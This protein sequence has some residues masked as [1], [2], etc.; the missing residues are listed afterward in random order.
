[1]VISKRIKTI[2]RKLHIK[3]SY[4]AH[5]MGVSQQFY[6]SIESGEKVYSLATIS[7]IATIFEIDLL[8]ILTPEIPITDETITLFKK[9]KVS[10]IIIN[11]FE[12]NS[13]S[14]RQV[15]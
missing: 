3:Q 6:S 1:M 12:N 13:Q 9:K 2:R 8:F 7:K 4:V 10:D 5:K 11:Y 14:L 15:I